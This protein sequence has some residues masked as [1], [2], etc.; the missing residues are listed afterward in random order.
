M[1]NPAGPSL[2]NLVMT[3]IIFECL[4]NMKFV[5][6][7]LKLYVDDTFLIIPSD[8]VDYLLE[9][10]NAYH[11]RIQ[12][13]I[14]REKDNELSFL[15]VRVRRRADGTLSTRWCMKPTSS[16][17]LLNYRSDTCRKYKIS[18]IK[19]LLHRGIN[20]SSSEFHHENLKEIKQILK[21]N[22]YPSLLVNRIINEYK[23]SPSRHQ[24]GE[25]KETRSYFRF[26]F[27]PKLSSKISNSIRRV[28]TN[29]RLAFYNLKSVRS[30]FSKLEDRAGTLDRSNVV[31]KI[32]CAGCNR[33]YIGQTKQ[34]LSSRVRQHK[35]D[36][37]EKFRDKE[38]KTALALHSFSTGHQFDFQQISVLDG[39]KNWMKRNL[40]E[41]IHINLHDTVNH[42][43]DT[44]GLHQSYNNLISLF[45]QFKCR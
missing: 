23:P 35:N 12:F 36:C 15:D 26:P 5:V 32:P 22:A 34:L 21:V 24:L 43:S 39:E 2:A 11:P 37:H 13:T 28:S 16:G 33:C 18:V 31:Y 9:T 14:E 30:L 27:V 45:R 10:F 8:S 7:I 38:G 19:N 44:Q 41:M 29:S 25:T 17:R 42:R 40:S 4:K 6:T 1:G 20:L 3:E